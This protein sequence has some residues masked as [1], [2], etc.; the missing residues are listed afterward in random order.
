MFPI[1]SF[2]PYFRFCTSFG[3][4]GN[5]RKFF[6]PHRYGSFDNISQSYLTSGHSPETTLREVVTKSVL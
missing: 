4:Y 5:G 6:G 1:F 3:G 2:F